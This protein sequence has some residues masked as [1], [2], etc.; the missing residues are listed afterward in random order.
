MYPS[1]LDNIPQWSMPGIPQPDVTQSQP[2]EAYSAG[3]NTTSCYIAADAIRAY[4][5]SAGPEVEH[6]LGCHDGS[7]C[8]V[9]NSVVFE[10]MDHY[11]ATANNNA[12]TESIP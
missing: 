8:H 5:G 6:A 3:G 2:F 7:E 9:D 4:S 11:D 10:L 1:H 12:S